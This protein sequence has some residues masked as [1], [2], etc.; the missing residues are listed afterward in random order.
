MFADFGDDELL[1]V[2]GRGGQGVD[3]ARGRKVLIAQLL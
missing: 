2:I 1:N 3:I